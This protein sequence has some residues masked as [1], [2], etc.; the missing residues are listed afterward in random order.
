MERL[1]GHGAKAVHLHEFECLSSS[2]SD[3]ERMVSK[4]PQH[5]LITV[6]SAKG[7]FEFPRAPRRK[8]WFVYVVESERVVLVVCGLCVR[9]LTEIPLRD[10]RSADVKVSLPRALTNSS[11]QSLR[12]STREA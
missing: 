12:A 8:G 5:A 7:L 2:I 11:P 4:H 3:W 9:D 1:I 10:R 6:S